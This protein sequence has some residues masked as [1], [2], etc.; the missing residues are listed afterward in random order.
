MASARAD[1][2]KPPAP[3]VPVAAIQVPKAPPLVLYSQGAVSTKPLKWK[4]SSPPGATFRV[5]SDPKLGD[6]FILDDPIPGTTYKVKQYAS[7]PDDFDPADV[8]ITV[9]LPATAPCPDPA[10][11]PPVVKP[12]SPAP[13]PIMPPIAA[14]RLGMTA[15]TRAILASATWD[16][17]SV[18]VRK[19]KVAAAF[20]AQAASAAAAPTLQAAITAGGAAVKGSID[21]AVWLTWNQL[22]VA[23]IQVKL[24]DL[25]A[26]RKINTPADLAEAFA[27]VATAL[28][29]D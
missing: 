4:L 2:P 28:Q 23:P 26:N 29:G 25:V 15:A 13:Q 16:A 5:F 9:P 22:L 20:A 17:A 12:P 18:Q 24:A 10:V 7:T 21:P 3:V 19:G 27:E 8:D 6:V 1:E 14:D 11:A